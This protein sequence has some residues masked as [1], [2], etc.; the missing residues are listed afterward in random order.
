MTSKR[1]YYQDSYKTR[2]KGRIVER[3]QQDGVTAVVLDR[4]CF[5][6]TSGGQPFDRG[7]M[8]QV[9]VQNVT[10]RETD[11]AILHWLGEADIWSDEITADIDWPRRFDHMQ[12][13][14]GQH[15]LSQAFIQAADAETVSFHLGEQSV[16]IDVQARDFK[17]ENIEYAEHLANQIVWQNRPV[18]IRAASPEEAQ[19]LPLRKIPPTRE[20]KLRLIEIDDF[21]LTA[22]G[23]THVSA[24]GEVGMIKIVKLERNGDLLRVEFCCG[25]RALQDYRLKN[26]VV[27]RLTAV[28][29]TGIPE[30][31]DS[32]SKLQ[33]EVKESR[34]TLKQQQNAITQLD[35]T[36]LLAQSKRKNKTIII[37]R[38]YPDSESNPGQLRALANR[39]MKEENVIALLGL[40]GEKSLLIFGRSKNA[41]GDM[42]QLIKPALQLLGS[43]SGGGTAE[44]AQGGGPTADL[45]RV[46]QAVARAER[47]LLGQL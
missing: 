40:A 28:L 6:P 3:V 8:N 1:L 34:R 10:I 27:S 5:Y 36:V 44:M 42:N 45:E 46:E 24:T 13:H 21:D 17:S 31:V 47:L 32:V 38:V 14:S 25:Q 35:A 26:S 11:G 22:C 33:T 15:I 23:G 16:T 39:L 19:Q 37:T 30:L 2:F 20:G 12:Q 4:T 29:T 41:P 7:M 9:P 18:R 43:A